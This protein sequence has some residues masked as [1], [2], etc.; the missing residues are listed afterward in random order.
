MFR[1]KS[2]L[3]SS[4]SESYPRK[5]PLKKFSFHIAIFQ[6]FQ[7]QVLMISLIAIMAIS[8]WYQHR[9]RQIIVT[10]VIVDIIIMGFAVTVFLMISFFFQS[11][12]IA[13]IILETSS[14]F[15]GKMILTVLEDISPSNHLILNVLFSR[16]Q[17]QFLGWKF[18]GFSIV[19]LFHIPQV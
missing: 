16:I 7:L 9:Y 18:M 4:F 1:R 8:F 3:K 17:S 12:T 13:V 2:A 14:W 15:S 10:E 11:Y 19:A 5:I 6:G